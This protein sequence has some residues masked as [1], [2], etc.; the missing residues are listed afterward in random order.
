M[1]YHGFAGAELSLEAAVSSYG[2]KNRVHVR[3]FLVLFYQLSGVY[4]RL[5]G[6]SN[7]P[8]L[9]RRG[10]SK[11][12]VLRDLAISLVNWS[13]KSPDLLGERTLAQSSS[14]KDESGDPKSGCGLQ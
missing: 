1:S 2:L 3:R 12:Y 4:T 9:S 7:T 6:E 10:R 5:P 8:V 13:P 11:M 14:L